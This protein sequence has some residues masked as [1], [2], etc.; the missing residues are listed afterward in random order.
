MAKKY[1]GLKKHPYRRL[2]DERGVIVVEPHY[3]LRLE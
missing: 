1:A 2:A 3:T